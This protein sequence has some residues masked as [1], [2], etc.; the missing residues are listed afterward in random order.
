M[1][2]RHFGRHIFQLRRGRLAERPAGTG[3][4]Q[5]THRGGIASIEALENRIVF[6]IHRQHAHAS[7]AGRLHHHLAGHDEDFLARHGD[8]LARLDRRQRGTQPA[9]SDNRD[10]N[11][12]R[13]GHCRQLHQPLDALRS[14]GESCPRFGKFPRGLRQFLGV[15]VRRHSHDPHPRGNILCHFARAPADRAGGSEDHDISHPHPTP[16]TKRM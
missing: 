13:F 9:G 7:P 5:T 6:A 16:S 2:Q 12:I 10:Q 11:Q 15:R 3:Q 1:P 4:N 14:A 8:V